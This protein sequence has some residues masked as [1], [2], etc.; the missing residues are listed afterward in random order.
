MPTV[1]RIGPYRI[2]FFSNDGVEPPHV[3]IQRD[4]ALAKFWLDTVE[5]AS[6]TGFRTH[7]LRQLERLVLD[8]QELA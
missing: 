7:E 5:L 3:H 2:F 1:A 8:N 6:T 4:R